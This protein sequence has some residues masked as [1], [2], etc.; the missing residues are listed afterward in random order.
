MNRKVSDCD[1][2][3]ELLPLYIEQ[4]TG[5]ESN[6]FVTE[7]MEICAECREV[8][9]FMSADWMHEAEADVERSPVE[10]TIRNPIKKSVGN[11]IEQ[12]MEQPVQAVAPK[13]WFQNKILWVVAG[14]L[15]Y[16]G[17]MAGLVIWVFLY[18]IGV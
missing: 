6:V 1:I 14:V 8:F 15:A 10:N 3:L 13:K 7:H 12:P 2:V 18:L 16:A 11:S 4:R 17:L 9:E 5:Q